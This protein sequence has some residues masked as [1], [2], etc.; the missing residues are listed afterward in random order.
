MYR[1]TEPPEPA[2]RRLWGALPEARGSCWLG[3]GA[4]HSAGPG[5]QGQFGQALTTVWGQDALARGASHLLG[6][7]GE[8]FH[9]PAVA[10]AGL[11]VGAR[12]RQ[13][14]VQ[15]EGF[16]KARIMDPRGAEGRRA[17]P[18]LGADQIIPTLRVEGQPGASETELPGF[19]AVRWRRGTR[20]SLVRAR[21]GADQRATDGVPPLPLIGRERRPARRAVDRRA[22]DIAW[23]AG[24]LEWA[25]GKPAITA[26]RFVDGK[27]RVSVLAEAALYVGCAGIGRLAPDQE[28][29]HG[30]PRGPDRP[31]ACREAS[32]DGGER[33]PC[34]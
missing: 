17:W 20:T 15:E 32:R 10:I 18:C 11:E 33:L 2:R 24:L 27:L 3:G 12:Q 34:S 16:V 21:E 28:A 26:Q 14:G 7:Y 6:R 19:V 29:G 25:E 1:S 30:Q 22:D 9:R 8:P 31:K 13:R 23:D 5:H 4:I